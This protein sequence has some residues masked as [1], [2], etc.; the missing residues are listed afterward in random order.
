MMR[1][2]LL[3]VPEGGLANRM[4][5]IASAYELCRR[6][7]SSLEVVW[8]KGWG[9]QAKFSDLFQ[10]VDDKIMNIRDACATDWLYQRPRKRNLW[11]S[12]VAQRL[13]FQ[14][15]M[16]SDEIL[17]RRDCFD[18]ERWADGKRCYMDNCYSFLDVNEVFYYDFFK[19]LGTI[20]ERLE[21]NRLSL[22]HT[23]IG[24]HIR[25]TDNSVA[26]AKSPLS[27]FVQKGK[28]DIKA[29]DSLVIYLATDSDDV[30]KEMR[31]VFG[32]RIITSEKTATRSSVEGIQ[33]GIVDMWSLS[34]CG[35]IYGSAGS[36]FSNM[37]AYLSNGK[38]TYECLS[39]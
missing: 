22:S 16:Y 2:K 8:F 35:K 17:R 19:P 11:L 5:S 39:L 32:E 33:D 29:N 14:R 4:L 7:D 13:L 20:K 9:M 24:M 21:K 38:A 25:R 10:Q 1:G 37:A 18:F 34:F 15:R 27:L 12:A 3:L 6:I 31:N 30:K 36:T 26:I 23:S 28:E